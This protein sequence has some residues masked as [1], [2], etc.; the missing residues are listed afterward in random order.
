MGLEAA[1][2]EEGDG[3]VGV[4]ESVVEGEVACGGECDG[5]AFLEAFVLPCD[6]VVFGDLLCLGEEDEEEGGVVEVG[7]GGE[8]AD[9]FADRLEEFGAVAWEGAVGG[10]LGDGFNFEPEGLFEW[11]CVGGGE[12]CGLGVGVGEGAG[13]GGED[14]VA[15]FAF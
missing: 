7:V 15:A 8:F 13:V 10:E 12:E 6:E 1:D 9:I 5:V 14:D 3:G 4:A 11:E 2:G